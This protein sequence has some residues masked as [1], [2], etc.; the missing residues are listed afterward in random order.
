MERQ[1]VLVGVS[2]ASGAP[3]AVELLRA[4]KRLPGVETHLICSRWGGRP[5]PMR[6]G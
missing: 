5:W 6:P 1:R 4:L 2:G 3:L